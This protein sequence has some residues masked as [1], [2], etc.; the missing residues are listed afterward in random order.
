MATIIK[1]TELKL[2]I[3]VDPID[4]WT[5]TNGEFDIEVYTNKN[6]KLNF[7]Q[8]ECIPNDNDNGIIIPID[9]SKLK[10]GEIKVKFTAYIPDLLFEDGKRTDIAIFNTGIRIKRE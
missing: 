9:T 4:D 7:N 3:N 5:L 6:N 1:G 10:E 2:G 8:K